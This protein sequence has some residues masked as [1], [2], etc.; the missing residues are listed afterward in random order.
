[1]STDLSEF[2]AE[3][4]RFRTKLE[5]MEKEA[6][7]SSIDNLVTF[8]SSP[9]HVKVCISTRP[10][11]EIE[12][13]LRDTGLIFDDPTI[14]MQDFTRDDVRVYIQKSLRS[15]DK[16]VELEREDPLCTKIITQIAKDAQGVWLWV[17]LVTRDVKLA[18]EKSEDSRKL[19][20][21]VNGFPK[22]LEEYFKQIIKKVDNNFRQ[23]MAMYFLVTIFELQPLPLYAFYLLNQEEI[24]PNYALRA[25]FLELL[26]EHVRKVGEEENKVKNSIQRPSCCYRWSSSRVPDSVSGLSPSNSARLPKGLVSR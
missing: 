3:V 8:I 17:Y 26:E 10:R 14:S 2:H 4:T 15:I 1:M 7:K 6:E 19:Y 16:L 18:A 23:E 25:D 11:P 9:Q 24:D 12:N 21:I 5:R 13:R 22:Q 20:D